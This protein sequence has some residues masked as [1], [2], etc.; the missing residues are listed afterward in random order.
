MKE[1]VLLLAVVLNVYLLF[2]SFELMGKLHAYLVIDARSKKNL[3]LLS[4][5]APIFGFITTCL[6]YQK[7]IKRA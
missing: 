2:R 4:V 3:Q 6:T 1:A 5:V 7:T